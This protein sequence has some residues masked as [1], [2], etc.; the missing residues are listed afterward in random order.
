LD[1]QIQIMKAVIIGGT[2]ASG[3]E[4]VK[5]LLDDERFQEVTVLVRRPYFG[6]NPKLKE[7]IINFEDL[8]S[9][10]DLIR[11]E[12]AF[13]CL[14]TTL[15][16]AGSKEAQWRVDHDYQLAFAA[17]AR[18]NGIG[19]FVLLSAH[20][21]NASSRIFYSKMKGSLEQHIT[22][23]EFPQLI[24]IHPGGIER[25][26]STR[27]G[28][29]L[30]I[31]VLKAFNAIGLFKGYEPLPTDRIAQGMIAAFF[32]YKGKNK[33]LGVKEIKEITA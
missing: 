27:T 12:V 19:A 10:G 24:I 31:P 29:K 7:V 30:F 23:L 1:K 8:A 33:I 22:Q 28:E 11:G 15:K 6:Q 26:N 13:S 21:A 2:G 3:K 20:G 5:R 4:V 16:D 25:P 9:Y 18:E 17:L 14:G 32:G